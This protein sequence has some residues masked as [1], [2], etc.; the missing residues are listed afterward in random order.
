M[1][2]EQEQTDWIVRYAW[3]SHPQNLYRPTR[4]VASLEEGEERARI[5]LTETGEHHV[6]VHV[7]SWTVYY[8]TEWK[9]REKYV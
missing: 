4:Y 9:E 3:H 2:Y 1:T 7:P 8:S 5:G 6:V